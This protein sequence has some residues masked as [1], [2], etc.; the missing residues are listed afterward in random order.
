MT[1]HKTHMVTPH[2]THDLPWC[3]ILEIL[4]NSQRALFTTTNHT[5]SPFPTALLTTH[6]IPFF[7]ATLLCHSPPHHHGET[8]SPNSERQ[9]SSQSL[10][11]VKQA[12]AIN[13][14]SLSH[15]PPMPSSKTKKKTPRNLATQHPLLKTPLPLAHCSSVPL[16]KITAT[17]PPHKHVCITGQLNT[18]L[19][20]Q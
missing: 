8:I 5:P 2:A 12:L 6:L 14:T 11:L 18:P 10:F 7:F 9:Q 15:L 4:Q 3:S 20:P 16:A 17:K 1:S 19:P 13:L